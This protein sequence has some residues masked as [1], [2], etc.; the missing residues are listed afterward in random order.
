MEGLGDMG[1]GGEYKRGGLNWK[2]NY[3][4]GRKR[5]SWKRIWKVGSK[6]T[7]HHQEDTQGDHHG[8]HQASNQEIG[9]KR[10]SEE[11]LFFDLRRIQKCL[12]KLL[13][14]RD[15]RLRDLH[16]ARQEE[17]CDCFGRGV[18]F[19][20]TRQNHLRIRRLSLLN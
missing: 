11:N 18:R 20:E 12:E 17:D 5:K 14:E 1:L 2:Y 3:Y 9:Q 15:Q 13:G 19:E 6:E 16:R 4:H 7:P 8:H 10:R